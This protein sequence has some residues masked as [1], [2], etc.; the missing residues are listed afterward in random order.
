MPCI[1]KSDSELSTTCDTSQP[2]QQASGEPLPNFRLLPRICP[3]RSIILLY[4]P[5]RVSLEIA[6][7][8]YYANSWRYLYA[9]NFSAIIERERALITHSHTHTQRHIMNSEYQIAILQSIYK[10][11]MN[12]TGQQYSSDVLAASKKAG[13]S[14]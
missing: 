6:I 5:V 8:R 1:S 10:K 13:L 14:R 3:R 9:K 12:G 2:K 4:H 11:G 7:N